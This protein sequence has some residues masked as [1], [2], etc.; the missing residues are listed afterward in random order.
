MSAS[1]NTSL[2]S[3]NGRVFSTNDRCPGRS[4]LANV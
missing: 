4:G 2:V 1:E 3:A